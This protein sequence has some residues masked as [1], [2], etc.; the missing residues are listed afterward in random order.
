VLRLTTEVDPPPG[1]PMR[2]TTTT[3]DY[4]FRAIGVEQYLLPV[5][6][7][8]RMFELP[9]EESLSHLTRSDR[10]LARRGIRYYNIVE[11]RD[12]R[13]FSTDSTLSFH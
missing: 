11:F 4:D 5:H 6:A 2:E 8:V 3:I 7:E 12:Y 1:F 10:E 9:S 13:K